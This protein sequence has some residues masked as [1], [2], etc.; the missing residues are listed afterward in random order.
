MKEKFK[1]LKPIEN[2]LVLASLVILFILTTLTSAIAQP[3][4]EGKVPT[5]VGTERHD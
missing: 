2:M 4:C 3:L 5:I 1:L